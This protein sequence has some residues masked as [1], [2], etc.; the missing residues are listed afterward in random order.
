MDNVKLS[1]AP[2]VARNAPKGCLRKGVVFISFAL[3]LFGLLLW[4]FRVNMGYIMIQQHH[5]RVEGEKVIFN[6]WWC[7][8]WIGLS[9]V[10]LV[11][12]VFHRAHPRAVT[13][14]V[15]AVF[16]VLVSSI[17][18]ENFLYEVFLQIRGV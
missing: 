3:L 2:P 11:A 18:V 7:G 12:Q 6:A 4:E 5:P 14:F 15:A 9:I 16:A 10:A 13:L 8:T 1:A 17:F